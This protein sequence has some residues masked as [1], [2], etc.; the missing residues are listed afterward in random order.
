M[1]K[2]NFILA[3]L[4]FT[5]LTLST[6]SCKKDEE[7]EAK[8]ATNGKATITGRVEAPLDVSEDA[9]EEVTEFAPKGT[10]IIATIDAADLAADP[11]NTESTGKIHYTTTVSDDK[12]SYSLT[13]D[14]NN[15]P[16]T[17]TIYPQDFVFDQKK[18]D[19][20]DDDEVITER[21]IF[22][23]GTYRVGGV[24]KGIT[25]IQDLFYGVND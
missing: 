19:P 20:A 4:L 8:T 17:V 22:K 3:G 14:A 13:V 5:A 15:N 9:G 6:T 24:V 23:A 11:D 21:E 25:K 10:V 12:G 1:K 2:I 18:I 7:N 16:L